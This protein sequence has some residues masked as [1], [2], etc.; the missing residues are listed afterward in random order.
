MSNEKKFAKAIKSLIKKII[1]SI[2]LI[3]LKQ[4]YLQHI[5]K[6]ETQL[7]IVRW[8]KDKGDNSLRYEYP[9]S[10][11]SVV[12]DLG[13]YKGDFAFKINERYG[14]TVLVYEPVEEFYLECI[15]RFKSNS[16]IHVFNYGLSDE[17]A[18]IKISDDD[19]GSSIVRKNSSEKNKGVLIKSFINEF[20]S[21]EISKIDL[22]KI[23]IEGPEFLLLPHIIKNNIIE[24]IDNIQVQFHD[25]YP[26]AIKLRELI[27]E[28]L[29]MTHSEEWNYTFVWESWTIKNKFHP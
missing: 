20:N 23:N 16:K 18:V 22:L 19:N 24:R 12:F 28:R 29:S 13:G 8:N 11:D 1:P 26:N 27:R 15:E 25:F 3:K 2:I 10:N 14:C 5:V 21:R 6:D 7:A 17:D 9:L 4:F